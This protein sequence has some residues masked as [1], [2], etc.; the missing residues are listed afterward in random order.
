MKTR[1]FNPVLL[2]VLIISAV[3]HGVGLLGLGAIT[4]YQVITEEEPEFEA[5]IVVKAPEPPPP[6]VSINRLTKKSSMSAA[7]VITVTQPSQLNLPSANISVPKATGRTGMGRGFG[8]GLDMAD[9]LASAPTISFFGI[10]SA[11]ERF[12]YIVDFSASMRAGQRGPV[13]RTELLRSLGEL[14][15]TAMVSVLFFSGHV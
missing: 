8:G 2:N 5:P 13:M 7:P 3:A 6:P 11:G 14:P 9:M 1:R 12:A 15:N 10:E 4:L